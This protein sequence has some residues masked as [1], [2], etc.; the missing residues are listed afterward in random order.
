M[1]FLYPAGIPLLFAYLMRHERRVKTAKARSLRCLHSSLR[2]LMPAAA[3]GRRF[4]GLVHWFRR[5]RLQRQGMPRGVACKLRAL[6]PQQYRL[7]NTHAHA[8]CKLPRHPCAFSTRGRL[9]RSIGSSLRCSANLPWLPSVRWRVLAWCC[10]P[11]LTC[12]RFVWA[13]ARCVR[14]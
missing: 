9:R 2:A 6:L 3:S 8:V 4:P 12:E 1:C 10:A 13:G 7:T 14:R 11:F 5:C